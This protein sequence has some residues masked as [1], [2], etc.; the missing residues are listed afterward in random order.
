VAWF[1]RIAG[2]TAL[3][4]IY[5]VIEAEGLRELFGEVVGKRL[6]RAS[7]SLCGWMADY[8]ETRNLDMAN[9]LAALFLVFSYASF[10]IVIHRIVHREDDETF[11]QRCLNVLPAVVLMGIDTLLF[12][13]GVYANGT[14]D[15][16]VLAVVLALGYDAML[17]LFSRWVITIERRSA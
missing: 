3:F 9:G 14:F 12:A 10:E 7:P 4:V 1:F 16:P 5:Q 13:A 2:L 15:S 17:I 6:W 8:E 11:A